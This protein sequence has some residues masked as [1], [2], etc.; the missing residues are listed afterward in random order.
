MVSIG[1][2]I[3]KGGIF[4]ARGRH[5]KLQASQSPPAQVKSVPYF[6][7]VYPFKTF[8]LYVSSDLYLR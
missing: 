5:F 8:F 7:C 2:G 1:A 3:P 6:Q 4:V